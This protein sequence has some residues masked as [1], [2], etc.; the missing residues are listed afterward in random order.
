[1]NLIW[2]ILNKILA[3]QNQEHCKKIIQHDQFGFFLEM[4]GWFNTSKINKCN[5]PYK[6]NERKIN[7]IISLDAKKTFDKS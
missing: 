5:S 7:M 4:Q 1:M 6:Q 3:N 2:K